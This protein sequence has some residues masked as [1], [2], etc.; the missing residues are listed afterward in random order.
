MVGGSDDTI[1]ALD[2]E[3]ENV[4]KD[5][6][7]QSK[8]SR[9]RGRA[10]SSVSP[11]LA[12]MADVFGKFFNTT[13]HSIADILKR[14]GYAQDHFEVR[15]KVYEVF[16]ILPLDTHRR[17]KIA[18]MIVHDADKVDLFFSLL[19][20]DKMEWVYLLVQGYIWE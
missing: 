19:D 12:S 18:S 14:I 13:N 8:G 11:G 17:M 6:D 9:K 4:D 20:G 16:L 15:K 5:N 2:R 7:S 3:E 1:H 10:V